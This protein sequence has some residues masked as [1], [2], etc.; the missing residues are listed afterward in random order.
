MPDKAP[1]ATDVLLFPKDVPWS[2]VNSIATQQITKLSRS[3]SNFGNSKTGSSITLKELEVNVTPIQENFIGFRKREQVG[4]RSR[5][6]RTILTKSLIREELE[7]LKINMS[8]HDKSNQLREENSEIKCKRQTPRKLFVK[9]MKLGT[10]DKHK[11]QDLVSEIEGRHLYTSKSTNIQIP[12]E[13]Q[14]TLFIF[15]PILYSNGR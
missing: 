8:S 12:T 15:S 2:S 10:C 7:I 9:Y 11:A 6:P 13:F 14:L 5:Y 1:E 4:S 3:D